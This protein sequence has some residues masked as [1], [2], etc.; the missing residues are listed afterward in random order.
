VTLRRI[1]LLRHGQT[2]Y[3]V[4]G[5]MQGHLDS[6]LTAVGH[7]QAATAAP[8]IAALG[9]DRVVSSDLRRAV[10]TAE[11]VGAACGLPVKYDARLRETHLGRWQGRTVAEIDRDHPGAIS[12]WRSDPEW[13]PPGGESR[14][15]VVARSRPVVDEL[16][17]EF[18][19]SAEEGTTVLLVAHGGLIAGL[20]T[21]LMELPTATWPSFG[22]LGNCRWAVLARRADHPRWR[23]AGYNVGV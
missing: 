10:D 1:I 16:D 15:A 18:A 23:L 19:D 7:E 13:A 14:V 2:D 4:S 3:N 21:G 5:R 20:V 12:A 11:V 6:T 9:P 17:A 22:G 8:L